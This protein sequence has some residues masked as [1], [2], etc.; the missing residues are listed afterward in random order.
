MI[1]RSLRFLTAG[2]LFAFA[3]SAHAQAPEP[4]FWYVAAGGGPSFFQDMTFTG[5]VVGD[6]HMDTGFTGNVAVGRYL[7]DVRVL[8]LELEGVYAQADINNSAGFQ[9][10]GDI[11]NGSLM[12]NL[13]YDIHTGSPW[14]PFVGGGIGHSWVYIDNL[15]DSAGT[16]FIDDSTSAF[17]YQF[18]A[19]VA[20]QFNP[21]LAATVTY[22]YFG[23]NSLAFTATSGVAKSGGIRS[24]NA[25]FGVR[26]NF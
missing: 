2:V 9:V 14:V 26:F 6:I 25:E 1:L 15:T 4:K 13:L 16:T 7:D 5:A 21:N 12:V 24:H 17:A 10:G 8:R 19:G 3:A 11:S 23:T 20:Y 22:R 18:K